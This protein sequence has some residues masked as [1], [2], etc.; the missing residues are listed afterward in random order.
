VPLSPDRFV[1]ATGMVPPAEVPSTILL[2]GVLSRKNIV[3][4]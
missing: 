4:S 3:I 2:V 1:Q